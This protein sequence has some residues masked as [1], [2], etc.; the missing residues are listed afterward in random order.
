[1]EKIWPGSVRYGMND[2][3][4]FKFGV[5]IQSALAV[6]SFFSEG[7]KKSSRDEGVIHAVLY[8]NIHT[9]VCTYG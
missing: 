9:P 6:I 1:M 4:L 8:G 7:G 5:L 3:I 2:V